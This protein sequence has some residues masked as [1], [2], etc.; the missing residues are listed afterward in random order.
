[1]SRPTHNARSD[2]DGVTIEEKA[3]LPFPINILSEINVSPAENAM[4]KLG[5]ATCQILELEFAYVLS[6]DPDVSEIWVVLMRDYKRSLILSTPVL[7]E[8][9]IRENIREF[10]ERYD[11]KTD[12][13]FGTL[14]LLENAWEEVKKAKV[15]L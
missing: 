15:K 11:L 9:E 4:A 13:R 8:S 3:E 14:T 5:V 7:G 2:P 6:N 1:M 10:N 12:I